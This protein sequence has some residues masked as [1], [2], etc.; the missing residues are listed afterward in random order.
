MTLIVT[1]SLPGLFRRAG[2]FVYLSI[3][4]FYF[5][6]YEAFAIA[7]LYG[8]ALRSPK[9]AEAIEVNVPLIVGKIRF[10]SMVLNA[11]IVINLC[12]QV[13]FAAGGQFVCESVACVKFPRYAAARQSLNIIDTLIIIIKVCGE[14]R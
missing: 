14:S 12:F 2:V 6:Y 9:R 4:N 1:W 7:Q 3:I 10:I 13:G 11:S 8:F 5:I